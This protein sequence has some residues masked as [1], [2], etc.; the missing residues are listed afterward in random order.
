MAGKPYQNVFKN[1]F[2]YHT[3][4]IL[5]DSEFCEL[6]DLIYYCRWDESK[7]DPSSV[8]DKVKIAWQALEPTISKSKA[9]SERENKGGAPKGNKNASKN[10]RPNQKFENS[11]GNWVGVIG[12]NPDRLA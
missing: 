3:Q 9:M 8:S 12:R 10:M 4:G 7:C 2:E 6:M 5:N 11:E 1:I